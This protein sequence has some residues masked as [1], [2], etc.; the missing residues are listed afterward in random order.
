MA[1]VVTVQADTQAEAEAA[2]AS[3]CTLA[4]LLPLAAGRAMPL[5]G[6][7]RWMCRAEEPKRRDRQAG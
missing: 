4:G 6:R 3:L 7:N 2:L 1:T 5:P